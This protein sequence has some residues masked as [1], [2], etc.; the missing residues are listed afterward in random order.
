MYGNLINGSGK[1]VDPIFTVPA[2]VLHKSN[3]NVSSC[4]LDLVNRILTKNIV[5]L[6]SIMLYQDFSMI[7]SLSDSIEVIA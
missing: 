3:S 7:F 1:L 5:C 6:R 2:F 4:S